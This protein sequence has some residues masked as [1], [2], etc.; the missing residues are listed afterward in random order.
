MSSPIITR[1][2]ELDPG[3]ERYADFDRRRFLVAGAVTAAM[4]PLNA[5][6]GQSGPIGQAPASQDGWSGI[7]V[8][9]SQ[10]ATNGITL[11]AI[12]L[13]TGKPVV[14]CHGFP[15][16]S[17]TWH[18]QMEAV[19]A[20]GYRAIALDMRGYGR[21]SA[22]AD[23]ALY[24]VLHTVGDLVGVLDALN[25]PDAT[26][27]GHDFGASVA[28]HAALLRP[29][30]FKAVFCLSV[31]YSVRGADSLLETVR[32]SGREDRFYMFSQIRPQAEG[33]WADA[34]RA[35]PG[36]L[37][38]G[39]GKPPAATRWSPFDP[40]RRQDRRIPAG[41]R[42]PA[43][44]AYVA[45]NVAEFRRTGFHGPLNYYRAIQATHDLT[46]PWKGAVIRQ[47]SFFM[48]GKADG[49]NEVHQQTPQA[50]RAGLPGLVGFV[51]LDGIGHWI[52]HEA[53]E[54][55]NRALLGFL[56]GLR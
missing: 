12:E 55:V 20:A 29:D 36:T 40:A 47:P 35:I 17:R 13:G 22:P 27:V 3:E 32:A 31:A 19:A 44:P 51:E 18:S 33:E 45:Y 38:W 1:P 49:L 28:W 37:Y 21:S 7:P 15:D 46:A 14:F 43:D 41:V 48:I 10:I 54:A 42:P 4:L 30:R 53:P 9:H 24:T 50:L 11:H 34:A 6:A 5:H 23:A 25:L 2:D 8:K 26:V 16:T 52:Q 39:S 56:R